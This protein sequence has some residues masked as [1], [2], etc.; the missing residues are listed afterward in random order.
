[1]AKGLDGKFINY[2]IRQDDLI[3]INTLCEKHQVDFEWLKEDILRKF[4][5]STN[6][7][8]A[9]VFEVTISPEMEKKKNSHYF[10]IRQRSFS[11]TMLPSI[12]DRKKIFLQLKIKILIKLINNTENFYNFILGNHCCLSDLK[13]Q[14]NPVITY[15]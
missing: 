15:F 7:I 2:G 4:H 13:I 6:T 1:M 3:L 10:T 5:V 12:S 11:I 14:N 8:D 9:I